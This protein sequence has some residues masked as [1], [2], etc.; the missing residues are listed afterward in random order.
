MFRVWAQTKWLW[1]VQSSQLYGDYAYEIA[2]GQAANLEA[3]VGGSSNVADFH[4]PDTH[5]QRNLDPDLVNEAEK[6]NGDTTNVNTTDTNG[7]SE[8]PVTPTETT[9][10]R[11]SK[12]RV[13]LLI[14]DSN[15][16]RIHF[17]DP[18]IKNISVSGSSALNID[19]LLSKAV[20]EAGDK[21]VKRIV[22]HLGANDI[23]RYN[24]DAN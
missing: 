19:E 6:S 2:E 8:I 11:L 14:G 10:D 18:D 20:T 16:E 7:V 12:E 13:F 15:S 1:K 22:V 24:A 4:E 3:S 17:K 5:V 9:F 23:T 21:K